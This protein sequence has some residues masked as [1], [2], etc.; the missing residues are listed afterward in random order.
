MA[1]AVSRMSFSSILFL[2]VF[3]LDQPIGGVRAVPFE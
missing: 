1:S 3:Q 2:K